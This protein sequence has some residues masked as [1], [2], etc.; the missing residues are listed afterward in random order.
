M[1]TTCCKPVPNVTVDVKDNDM[2]HDIKCLANCN[3]ECCVN[4]KK[5]RHH[6][7]HHCHKNFEIDIKDISKITIE[8]EQNVSP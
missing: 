4:R 7:K 1:G 8:T 5:H 6:N 3:S 2:C